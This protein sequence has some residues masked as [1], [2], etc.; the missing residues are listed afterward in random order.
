MNKS[1][2]YR[3]NYIPVANFTSN[4]HN[5]QN[6]TSTSVF[7]DNSSLLVLN[8][9]FE[10]DT[11]MNQT[12]PIYADDLRISSLYLYDWNDKNNDTEISSDE[13]SL[14]NRGGSWGTVQE[15]RVTEPEEKFE[16][17]P[18]VG[19]YPVPSRYSFWIGDINKNSTSMDYSLTASYFEKDSWNDLS[20]KQDNVSIPPL[21]SVKIN[22]TITTSSDQKTGIYDGFLLFEGEHHS[23]NVPVTYTVKHSSRKRHSNCNSWRTK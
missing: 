1:K 21:S 23:L 16:D 14:V 9:N 6:S 2:T 17:T 10:F 4:I 20:V 11:F 15:L 8:A 19:V 5:E 3:P 13:L 7:P 12:N 22:S 18:V